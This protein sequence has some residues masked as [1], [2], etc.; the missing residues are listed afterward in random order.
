M[1]AG[2][3]ATRRNRN[4]GTAKQGIG[5]NNK[6]EIPVHQYSDKTVFHYENLKNYRSVKRVINTSLI[7]FLV[8][9]TR[10]DCIHACTIDDI[11][12]VL[13]HVPSAEL[14]GIT[15]IVLRQPKRKEE[16]LSSAW[17]RYIYYAEIDEY[18]GSA[19]CLEAHPL[20]QPMRWP[21]S[22]FPDSQIELE[23]LKS[24]GHSVTTAKRHHI[25]SAD[26][27]VV[28]TTQLYRTL[29]H[30]IG[31][32]VDR[33]KDEDKFSFKTSKDKEIF[34]HKYADTLR[35]SL[36]QRGILPFERILNLNSLDTDKLRISDFQAIY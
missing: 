19:I 27:T 30:E 7:S 8:E 14:E 16:I 12:R 11:T 36:E 24:D 2:R 28:R 22:L 9:E 35:K 25:V 32:H 13:Q 4:I 33:M 31:H 29:L 5:Q 26:L 10:D 20:T 15:L 21:K 6:F 3:N 23:R 17:G 1:T 18:R 34:A